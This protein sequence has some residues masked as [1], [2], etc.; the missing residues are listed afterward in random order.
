MNKCQ[1]ALVAGALISG[2]G[3]LLAA[4]ALGVALLPLLSSAT[5]V[6]VALWLGVVIATLLSGFGGALAGA[7]A[8]GC[9]D[10]PHGGPGGPSPTIHVLVRLTFVPSLIGA[11]VGVV[12]LSARQG[13]FPILTGFVIDEV[14]TILQLFVVLP[15]VYRSWLRFLGGY[16]VARA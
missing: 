13:S 9:F 1:A 16:V 10:P 2:I 5:L 7:V 11:A 8:A 4:G 15:I 14:G 12:G 6:Y 3:N